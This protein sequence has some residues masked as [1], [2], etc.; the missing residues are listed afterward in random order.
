MA[1]GQAACRLSRAQPGN[2]RFW[3]G[4]RRADRPEPGEPD[5]LNF[6][7][8]DYGN[9]VGAWRLL[10]LFASQNFPASVLINSSLYDEAP[11][12]VAAV[13]QRGDEIVGHGR[14]NCERQGAMTEAEERALIAEATQR[15]RR[16]RGTAP[17][18][19]LGPWISESATTPDLL[20]EAGYR[21][22]LDWAMDDQPIFL[23][24]RGDGRMLACPIR[25][26]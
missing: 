7:W 17:A 2:L 24:T 14:T 13:L 21:Y 20:A 4:T 6:S 3:R 16:G 22:V 5:I 9:R 25:R 23:R 15:L 1:G 11:E 8:R 10:D 18:G 26:N 12:L 19:W